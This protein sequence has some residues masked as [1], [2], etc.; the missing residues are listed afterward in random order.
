MLVHAKKPMYPASVVPR[1][2]LK[3]LVLIVVHVV[4]FMVTMFVES[5]EVFGA[6]SWHA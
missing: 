2:S 6:L 3:T 1:Q 4:R 5:Y